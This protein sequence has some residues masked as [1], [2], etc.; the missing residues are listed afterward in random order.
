M[1]IG[2]Q[3]RRANIKTSYDTIIIGSGM[4]GL[5]CA[6]ILAQAGQKVLVLER[7][8]T[9]GG[10]THTFQRK[11]YEWDVG[12]HY[13][14]EVHRP[15][16]SIRRIFDYI[17]HGNLKWAEMPEVYDK[18]IIAGENFDYIKGEQ[19][20]LNKMVT[21]FPT[22]EDAIHK[23]LQLVKKA[24]RSVSPHFGLNS[25]PSALATT[26][27][28]FVAKEFRHFAALKTQD[29]LRSLT[30]NKKLEAVLTGQWGDYGLPPS[31][32]SFVMHAMVARHYLNGAAYPVGGSRAI[33]EK[34]AEVLSRHGADLVTGAEVKNIIC[35]GN[36][37]IGVNLANGTAIYAKRIISAVGVCNTFNHLLTSDTPH[38]TY[39]RQKI[40]KIP[41]SIAHLGLYIGLKHDLSQLNIPASNLWIYE[42]ENHD[43]VYANMNAQEFNGKFPLVYI[44]FP[45]SKDPE[46]NKNYPGKSTIEMVV[47]APYKWFEKWRATPWQKRGDDYKQFK[48]QITD[49]LLAMLYKRFPELDGKIHYSELSTPL[50]T[51]NFCNYTKG[52]IY[53]LDH[54]PERFQQNWLRSDTKI[55]N[56]FI[57][58]QDIVSCGV[59]GALIA[60]VL[61]SARI[62]GPWKSRHILKLM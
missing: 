36:Q 44:S 57:T 40:K 14:G 34:I 18:V 6:S 26:L 37:A 8:Y 1:T 31:Q 41:Q 22:E 60:G 53:G 23:Y 7:H 45:S 35:R 33:A 30:K 62:L 12:V 13:I 39:Y 38:V 52:E 15:H 11:G 24:A 47:P 21:Y 3:L 27:R 42:S 61:T 25:L 5:T 48:E 10:F 4:G 43:E 50:S 20:F 46:W 51:E 19:A 58:G 55:Q 56:L 2:T 9:A 59:S 29:V 49:S 16:S 28:P 54:T 17:S 32:S